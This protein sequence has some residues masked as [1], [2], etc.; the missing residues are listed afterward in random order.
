MRKKLFIYFKV[1]GK[2]FL[3]AIPKVGIVIGAKKKRVPT[4]TWSNSKDNDRKRKT[5]L[6]WKRIC[7]VSIC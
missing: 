4:Y 3:C 7:K 2:E 5:G 1:K 6:L